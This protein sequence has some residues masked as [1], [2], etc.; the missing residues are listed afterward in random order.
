MS[1]IRVPTAC[2][3]PWERMRPTAR[4]RHCP[5]CDKEVL[6][7]RRLGEKRA[8]ALALLFGGDHAPCVRIRTDQ[9]GNAVFREPSKKR[10]RHLPVLVATLG[11]GCSSA[12]E[13]AESPPVPSATEV[14]SISEPVPA[15]TTTA[16]AGPASDDSTRDS[17]GD[18]IADPIDACPLE[19]GAV[20]PPKSNGCPKVIVSST[21]GIPVIQKIEFASGSADI[22]K[23]S[24]PVLDEIAKVIS[25]HPELKRIAVE[26]HTDA[27]EPNPK[28]LSLARARAVM[29]YLV[30]KGVSSERLVAKGLGANDPLDSRKTPEAFE[31]N[32]RVQF[33]VLEQG[34]PTSF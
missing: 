22:N 34:E 8:H 21:S 1:A 32:R 14:A 30:K 2:T 20:G 23:A 26:A 6:D 12:S 24:Q 16:S 15:P 18:G 33:R 13:P 17:D 3:V 11:V 29:R 4:G 28:T 10:T 7:L 9:D 25:E 19:A 27:T 31:K 5:T